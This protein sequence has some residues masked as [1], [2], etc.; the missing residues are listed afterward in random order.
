MRKLLFAVFIMVGM[1]FAGCGNG[2]DQYSLERGYFVI[3]K[4]VLAI[5][6]NPEATPRR[7]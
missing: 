2:Q 6:N 5:M 4:K 7:N 1:F 3:Q